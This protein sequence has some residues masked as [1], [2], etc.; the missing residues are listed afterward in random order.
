[1]PVPA[2]ALP[3]KLGF[4]ISQLFLSFAGAFREQESWV[5]SV[6]LGVFSAFSQLFSVFSVFSVL[7]AFSVQHDQ[8][9]ASPEASLLRK[10]KRIS[11]NTVNI[12]H[13]APENSVFSVFS[14][15]F[16]FNSAFS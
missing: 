12:I 13:H 1:M 9:A 5:F 6:F 3:E 7:S 10:S 4:L 11:S 8:A 2:V 15:F 16:G 14:G